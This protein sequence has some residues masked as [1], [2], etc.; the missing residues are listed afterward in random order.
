MRSRVQLHRDEAIIHKSVSEVEGSHFLNGRPRHV[1]SSD[2]MKWIRQGWAH[3]SQMWT[4]S[5]SGN[6]TKV[7]KLALNGLP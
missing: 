3:I 5:S 2:T 7:N 4:G 1:H 6:R